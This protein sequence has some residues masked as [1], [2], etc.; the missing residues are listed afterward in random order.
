MEYMG[1]GMMEI[2]GIVWNKINSIINGT[3]DDSR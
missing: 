3:P 2:H 1:G